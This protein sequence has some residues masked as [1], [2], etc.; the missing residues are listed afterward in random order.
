MDNRKIIF[1]SESVSDGHP[2]K[3]CDQISDAILDAYLSKDKNAKVACETLVTKDLVVVA[4]EINSNV[5]VN[6]ETVIRNV[7]KDIGY[8]HEGN[9]FKW[10]ELEIIDRL[11]K[12]SPDIFQG[13]ELK[14]GEIGSG[15]QGIMFGYAV[16]E[17]D[18]YMPFPIEISHKLLKEL[19]WLRENDDFAKKYLRPDAKS[20][21]TMEYKGKIPQK[22]DTILI[23]TQHS[24]DVEISDI[25][26]WI[27]NVLVERVK[28]LYGY[29]K[30]F[31]NYKLL[32]N[33]TGRF[34]IGGPTGDGGLTGRKI[35]VDQYGGKGQIGGGAFSGKDCS[36]TDRSAAYAARWIAKNIVASGL[37]DECL[38]Q[39][40]YA[41]GVPEP[42]S[43]NI[44]TYGTS[45]ISEEILEDFVKENYPLTPKWIIDKLD[46]R[47]VNYKETS[48]F[49]H[50]GRPEFNW[51]K[52]NLVDD[53]KKLKS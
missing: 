22:I 50:F 37:V 10:D 9:G 12:Q 1:T 46:L 34:V 26:G 27:K 7:V 40:S 45:R 31:T 11:H 21:V 13:V 24:E 15:D 51:E 28:R 19:K 14:T 2:D 39:L 49:G 25:K 52:L 18:N 47:N 53:F 8:I 4:G 16:N 3:V 23:S 42:V 29:E 36:K 20:Q 33:P 48:T 6:H 32:V 43:I 44:H 41:I 5:K 30:Y 38:I 35:V 17:S